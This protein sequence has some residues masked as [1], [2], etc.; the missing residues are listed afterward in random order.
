MTKGIRHIPNSQFSAA[1]K[2]SHTSRARQTSASLNDFFF[3]M[4]SEKHG[5]RTKNSHTP[6]WWQTLCRKLVNLLF[7]VP[8][9]PEYGSHILGQWQHGA[10]L[11]AVRVVPGM[12]PVQ[13]LYC[14]SNIN[15]ATTP[16]RNAVVVQFD[17]CQ[18]IP[19]QL[20]TNF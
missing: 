5:P 3:L 17:N 4:I 6:R 20:P 19:S 7:Q 10:F 9:R 18:C 8:Y 13:I 15:H 16:S 2:P 14:T 1:G 12:C 11:S